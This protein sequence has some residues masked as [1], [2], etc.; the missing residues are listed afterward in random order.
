MRWQTL[1][2]AEAERPEQLHYALEEVD[3]S[4]YYLFWFGGRYGWQPPAQ[5]LNVESKRRQW[6]SDFRG[7]S[8]FSPALGEILFERAVLSKIEHV[9]V[10]FHQIGCKDRH[11]YSDCKRVVYNI[12]RTRCNSNFM[13]LGFRVSAASL[14]RH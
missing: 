10:R 3:R 8:T 7:S 12:H 13:H 6:L 11:N 1:D 9:R 14:V 4:G 2:Q 5:Q